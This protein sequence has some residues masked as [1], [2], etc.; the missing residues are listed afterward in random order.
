MCP[1]VQCPYAHLCRDGK[2]TQEKCGK[3][4]VMTMRACS[5]SFVMNAVGMAMAE[6]FW[7]IVE[8]MAASSATGDLGDLTCH[9]DTIVLEKNKA[10]EV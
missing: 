4:Q 2:I 8:E 1:T 7:G 10:F 3:M 9:Y 5:E 6:K